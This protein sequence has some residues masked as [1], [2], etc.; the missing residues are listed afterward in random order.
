[1]RKLFFLIV[2]A[3]LLVTDVIAQ[4][5]DTIAYGLNLDEVQIVARRI[6]HA[7]E[8]NAGAKVT[9]LEPELL[10]INKTR[11][12]SE[13][14]TENSATYIKSLGT[15]ALSTASFR[16]GSAAQTGSTGMESTS[17][18]RCPE[19][20]TFRSSLSSLPTT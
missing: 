12:F 13:L 18:R 5:K 19:C 14:L 20:L 6:R 17:R 16:G 15:G 3:C 4:K 9:H 1:M 10:Q 11:S 7:N 8:A 2:A